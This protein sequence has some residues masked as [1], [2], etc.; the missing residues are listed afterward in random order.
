[1][2][3]GKGLWQS[4]MCARPIA[5]AFVG[6]GGESPASAM[7]TALASYN[8][9]VRQM[10]DY[11]ACLSREARADAE[12]ANAVISASAQRQMQAGQAEMARVKNQLFGPGKP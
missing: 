7:N 1:M 5:P 10:Q 8:Q 4:T 2:S 3:N 9:Y 11:L 6:V 12:A